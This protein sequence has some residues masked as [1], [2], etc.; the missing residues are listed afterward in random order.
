M[1]QPDAPD[2]FVN[3]ALGLRDS[4]RSSEAASI[5]EA[6]IAQWPSAIGYLSY[7]TALLMAGG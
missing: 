6:K 2:A 4:L 7:A 1:D 5:L 3:L